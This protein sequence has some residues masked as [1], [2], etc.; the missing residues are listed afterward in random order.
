MGQ[1]AL[2]LG[3]GGHAAAAWEIG[4]IS[5]MAEVGVDVRKADVV[6]GTSAGARVAVQITS[7]LT[8][9]ELFQR[10]V[11]P[12]LQ[13]KESAPP[14]DFLR[15]RANLM[16]AKEGPGDVVAALK[17]FGALALQTSTDLQETRRSMVAA[18]LPSRTW[19]DRCLL[20]VAV[21]VESG[22]RRC[23]RNLATCPI[24]R[25]TF[26]GWCHLFTRQ[27]RSCGWVRS[28]ADSHP[29]SSCTTAMR[30]LP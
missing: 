9:E 17:R 11:D 4:I 12:S 2:V 26:H 29:A 19:P 21:D 13:T 20:I 8:M 27:R 22:E 7:S 30:R 10:H 6:V 23:P 18:N 15:W 28:R 3:G 25:S 24:P 1:Q 14:V 16:R 5:G